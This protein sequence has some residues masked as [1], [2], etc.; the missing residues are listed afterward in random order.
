MS[1]AYST[2]TD[3]YESAAF[4]GEPSAA[5]P[6][7]AP[8]EDWEHRILLPASLQGVL[9]FASPVLRWSRVKRERCLQDHPADRDVIERIGD[10]LA[11]VECAGVDPRQGRMEFLAFFWYRARLYRVVMGHDRRGSQNMITVYGTATPKKIHCWS[12]SMRREGMHVMI[13]GRATFTGVS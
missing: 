7:V 13:P 8:W 5:P 4:A 9:G 10:L 6:L 1:D 3:A 12:E 2:L 11:L